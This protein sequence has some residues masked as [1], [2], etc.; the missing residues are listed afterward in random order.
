MKVISN[1]FRSCTSASHSAFNLAPRCSNK[2]KKALI[3]TRII[4]D[5]VPSRTVAGRRRV[6]RWN[7]GWVEGSKRRESGRKEVGNLQTAEFQKPEEKIHC[8]CRAGEKCGG[9]AATVRP[10]STD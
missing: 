1:Y 8:D 10:I 9:G 5:S 3:G 2:K 4:E 7:R 6:K